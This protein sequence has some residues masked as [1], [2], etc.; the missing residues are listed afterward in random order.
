MTFTVGEMRWGEDGG[1]D[2]EGRGGNM[3]GFGALRLTTSHP[4]SFC[5]LEDSLKISLLII[6]SIS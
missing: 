2:D 4:H 6:I 1:G 5:L 3:G